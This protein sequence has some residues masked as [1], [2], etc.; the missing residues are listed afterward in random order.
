MKYA[1]KYVNNGANDAALIYTYMLQTE[2]ITPSLREIVPR[3]HCP[4][5]PFLSKANLTRLHVA[6][7]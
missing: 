6:L 5:F 4:S 7:A 3:M 1:C 2:S